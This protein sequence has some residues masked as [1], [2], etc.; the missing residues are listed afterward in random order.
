MNSD[1]DPGIKEFPLYDSAIKR[2]SA[3]FTQIGEV[4][5]GR[6]PEFCG[7]DPAKMESF[8]YYY[9][10][11]LDAFENAH[12]GITDSLFCH[13]IMA[14]VVLTDKDEI[15]LINPCGEGPTIEIHKLLDM[16]IGLQ[17]QVHGLLKGRD[18]RVIMELIYALLTDLLTIWDDQAEIENQDGEKK[19]WMIQSIF[20][21]LLYPYKKC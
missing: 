3:S 6:I 19:T 2:N 21:K 14:A 8:N 9:P 17:I 16:C 13:K 15:C 10:K 5:F 4:Y 20:R 1:A 12:G 11:L 7:E 18:R